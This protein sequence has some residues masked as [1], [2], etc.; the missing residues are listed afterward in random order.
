MPS[1]SLKTLNEVKKLAKDADC[2]PVAIIKGDERNKLFN[3]FLCL[4]KDSTEGKQSLNLPPDMMYQLLPNTNPMHRDVTYIAGPS[5]CGKST[6]AKTL[7]LNYLKLYPHRKV[8]LVSNLSKDETLDSIKPPLTRID[9]DELIINP[10]VLEET[11]PS[12]W[13]FDDFD[14][15]EKKKLDQLMDFINTIAIQGRHSTT[16]LIYISHYLTNFKQ[17]RLMLNESHYFVLYP[18]SSSVMGLKYLLQTYIGMDKKDIK[19]LRQQGR[20]V[21]VHSQYPQFVIS[22]NNAYLL[23][24]DDDK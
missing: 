23:H 16:S 5:G 24:T 20:W 1:F 7:T 6:I 3:S 8:Y 21:C 18:Q 19:T 14:S 13:I 12:L 17:T 4:H 9:I 15:I 10:P 22:A 2:H 11:E